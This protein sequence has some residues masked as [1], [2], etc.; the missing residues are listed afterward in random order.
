MT[1]FDQAPA[2][3]TRTMNEDTLVGQGATAE[4]LARSRDSAEGAW[5]AKTR[6]GVDSYAAWSRSPLTGWTVGLAIPSAAIVDPMRRSFYA[7]TAAGIAISTLGLVC[8][9]LLRRRLVQAQLAIAATATNARAGPADLGAGVVDRRAAGSVGRVARGG[10][11]S[12]DAPARTR[13]AAAVSPSP[14]YASQG[15]GSGQG[16]LG[17]LSLA[18]RLPNASLA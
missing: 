3:V 7:I 6:E 4:F 2:I 11:D 12:Q 10:R 16:K 1:V 15:S 5:R 17:H 9:M 18:L 8:A 13:K 14:R